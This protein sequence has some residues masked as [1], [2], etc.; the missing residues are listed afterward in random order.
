M[1]ITKD[2]LMAKV[3]INGKPIDHDGLINLISTATKTA[4]VGATVL[5]ILPLLGVEVDTKNLTAKCP[6]L[7]ALRK[8]AKSDAVVKVVDSGETPRPRT[9]KWGTL[10]NRLEAAVK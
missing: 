10:V 3:E 2:N 7:E 5:A 1:S 4:T 8:M 6:N 9:F